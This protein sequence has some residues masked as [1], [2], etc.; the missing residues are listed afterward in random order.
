VTRLVV[1]RVGEEA[2]AVVHRVSLEAFAP[3]ARLDPPSGALSESVE[4]VADELRR[5]GGL[6]ALLDG[7]VVGSLRFRREPPALWVRRVGVVP[8]R[9]REG[10]GSALM[11]TAAGVAE[12]DGLARLHVGVRLALEANRRWYAGLGYAE[13][14]H[15]MHEGAGVVNWAELVRFVPTRLVADTEADTRA[16]GERLTAVLEPG[17]L[18]VLSGPLGAGKTVVA[19]GI[20]AGLGVRGPVLSP[21]FV[22]S[23]VHRGGRIPLVHVDAY[24]MGS[25][26]EIDDL[27]LDSSVEESVTVVEW[28]TGLVEGLSESHL[29]LELDRRP[30]DDVRTITVTP[31]GPAWLGRDPR[32]VTH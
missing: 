9:Q 27:D 5:H 8:A 7:A 29:L 20:G 12:E 14:G 15:R 1:E 10:I 31:F 2:A 30:D 17:D 32:A 26:A 4:F 6:V 24:R 22:I 28:G 21:T 23:R 16:I 3:Y 19:Q 13:V 11:T 25:V 18:V